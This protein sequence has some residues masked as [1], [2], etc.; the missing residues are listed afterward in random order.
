MIKVLAIFCFLITS[1]TLNAQNSELIK[2]KWIF[3]KA[4]NKEVDKLGRKSLKSE[5]IDKWNIEFKND[6][7]FD[8]FFF[9]EKMNGKWTLSNKSEM[10]NLEASQGKFVFKILKLTENELI[11]KFGLG[12]FI[13]KKI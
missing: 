8:G 11:L 4:I 6:G 1:I 13:M 12:E 2:G 10:I 3:K 9:G 5:V 7:D